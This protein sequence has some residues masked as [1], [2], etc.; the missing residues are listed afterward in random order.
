M[1]VINVRDLPIVVFPTPLKPNAFGSLRISGTDDIDTIF[2]VDS[3][4]GL[5]I[6]LRMLVKL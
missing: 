6:V 5:C 1:D 4:R 3:P 2:V